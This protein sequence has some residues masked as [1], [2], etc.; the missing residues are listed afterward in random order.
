MINDK[1]ALR[2]DFS[3][4]KDY[5]STTPDASLAVNQAHVTVD[6]SKLPNIPS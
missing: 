2:L 3:S 1:E 5:Y 6:Y 4:P